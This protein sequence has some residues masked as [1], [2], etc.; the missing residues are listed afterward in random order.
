VHLLMRAG[1]GGD[2]HGEGRGSRTGVRP[3]SL[4]LRLY[5]SRGVALRGGVR[6]HGSFERRENPAVAEGAARF[7][8]YTWLDAKHVAVLGHGELGILVLWPGLEPRVTRR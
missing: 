3:V 6:A 8:S 5:L 7:H 1:G 2:R 4:A